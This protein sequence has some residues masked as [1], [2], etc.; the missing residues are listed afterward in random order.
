MLAQT[1]L[2]PCP[3]QPKAAGESDPD[4]FISHLAEL[5]KKGLFPF[6][7]LITFYE[8]DEINA[9]IHASET[10]VAIKPVLRMA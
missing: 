8:F 7:K 2:L 9:A 10:G 4:E 1:V 6:D 5:Y 3:C